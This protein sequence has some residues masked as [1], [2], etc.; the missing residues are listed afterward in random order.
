MLSIGAARASADDAVP[1]E[2]SRIVA[3]VAAQNPTVRAAL[4]EVQ[5]AQQIVLAEEGSY[6]FVLNLEASVDAGKTPSLSSMGVLLPSSRTYRVGAT[7]SRQLPF[8]M[9]VALSLDGQRFQRN[10]QIVPSSSDTVQIGPG[11][12]LNLGLDVTQSLLRGF[13]TSVGWGDRDIARLDAKRQDLEALATASTAMADALVGYYELWYAE[14]ALVIENDA[15]ALAERQHAEALERVRLG[16]LSEVDALELEAQVASLAEQVV[17]K[18]GDIAARRDALLRLLGVGRER[19]TTPSYT[20]TEAPAVDLDTNVSASVENALAGSPEIA[21]LDAAIDSAERAA[22]IA[23]DA[24]RPRLD[25]SLSVAAQGLGDRD[26]VAALSQVGRFQAVHATAGV[27]Y[28][29]ALDTAP[30]RAERTRARLAVQVAEQRRAE[31]AERIASDVRTQVT[32]LE[33]A[34]RRA[35]LAETSVRV[36]RRLAEAQ[37][38]RLGLGTVTVTQVLEASNNLRE[39][40]LRSARALVDASVAAVQ[41]DRLTGMLATRYAAVLLP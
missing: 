23:G 26:A 36:A 18:E 21:A 31:A 2:P 3:E 7:I 29:M 9:N 35:T 6:G 37:T 28:E 20:A 11:Y 12:G 13:G 33:S 24:L 39:A 14:R 27:V 34:R 10:A 8:G 1:L 4:L 5:Q 32:A 38:E 30:Q 22:R 16:A 15:L 41:L 19:G 17:V 25:L 40:E